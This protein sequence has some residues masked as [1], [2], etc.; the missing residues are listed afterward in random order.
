M[1]MKAV[2]VMVVELSEGMLDEGYK[3][4]VPSSNKLEHAQLV[5]DKLQEIFQS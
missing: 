5:H 3:L 1:I 4:F 2:E